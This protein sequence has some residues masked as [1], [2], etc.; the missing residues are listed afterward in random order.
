[1]HLDLPDL[2]AKGGTDLITGGFG[3]NSFIVVGVGD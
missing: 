1:M 3:T 2:I